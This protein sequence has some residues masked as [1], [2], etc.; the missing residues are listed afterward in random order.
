M[1]RRDK[2]IL[3]IG[4]SGTWAISQIF[5]KNYICEGIDIGFFDKCNLYKEKFKIKKSASKISENDIKNFDVVVQLAAFSNDP[6]SNLIQKNFINL[7]LD[8]LLKLPRYKKYKIRFIFHQVVQFMDM[9]KMYFQKPV[10]L[11]H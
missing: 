11:N 1:T 3:I 8:T 9:E 10:K 6:Y 4:C 7:Q 5:K 2:K